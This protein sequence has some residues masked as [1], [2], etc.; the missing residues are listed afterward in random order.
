MVVSKTII[1]K[2][3]QI[4][5]VDTIIECCVLTDSLRDWSQSGIKGYT[6]VLSQNDNPI[7]RMNIA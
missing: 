5:I 1:L 4:T 7:V 3:G 6:I 2:R